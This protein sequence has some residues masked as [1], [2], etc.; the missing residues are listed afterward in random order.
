V[1]GFPSLTDFKPPGSEARGVLHNDDLRLTSPKMTATGA[2]TVY[3][4]QR[5]IDYVWLPDIANRGSGQVLITGTW[6]NPIYKVQS[7]TTKGVMPLPNTTPGSR[8]NSH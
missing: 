2:G 4:S 7:I 6:D 8:K 3:L 1:A 5:R